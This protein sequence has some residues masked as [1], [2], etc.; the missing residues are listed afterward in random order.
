MI[1]GA[2]IV[3]LMKI[4][5]ICNG[6]I[7]INGLVFKFRN[8]TTD[9]LD[10][11]NDIVNKN[12]NYNNQAIETPNCLLCGFYNLEDQIFNNC[13]GIC[14]NCVDLCNNIEEYT[15]QSL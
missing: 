5:D 8:S 15:F 13:N 7:I 11:F 6:N 10:L 4:E 1:F 3:S 14:F 12:I 2:D 9:D